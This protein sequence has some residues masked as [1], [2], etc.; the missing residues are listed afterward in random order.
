MQVL[1]NG[2]APQI[3]PVLAHPAIARPTPLPVAD[4]GQPML[5][6]DPFA[7]FGAPQWGQLPL[8]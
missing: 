1:H 4:V 7:Q 8:A 5:H 3:K 6:C 2:T